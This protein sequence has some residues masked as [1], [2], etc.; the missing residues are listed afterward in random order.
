MGTGHID[1]VYA[2]SAN[3]RLYVPRGNAILVFDLDT[4]S[5]AGSIPN[6]A[7]GHGVT[8]DSDSS[9]GFS[10]S[11]PVIMWESATLQTVKTISVQGHPDGILFEP[12]THRVYVFSHIAPNVTILDPRDGS[13][14]GT[15]DL[16]GFPEQ[17]ASD[18]HGHLYVDI[19]NK[20]K[21]A[22]IDVNAMKVSTTY[23]LGGKGG[24]PSGLALDA[25]NKILFAFCRKPAIAVILSAINGKIIK[26]LPIGNGTD[27]GVFNPATMEAFSSQGDG[28]LTIIKEKSPTDFSVEQTVQ[29]LPRA[30]TCTLDAK[31][32]HIVLIATDRPPAMRAYSGPSMLHILVVGR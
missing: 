5:P 22:V 30:K 17:A 8:V 2:D 1:Y 9:H 10:S 25:K 16:G 18:G 13:F 27:G 6:L 7:N 4:L 3:R 23:S 11:S 28:S 21:I 24:G 19:E 20:N 12:L 26:T 15:L 14:V 31:T 32:N 29:T